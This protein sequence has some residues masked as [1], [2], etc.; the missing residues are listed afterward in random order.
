MHNMKF[1]VIGYLKEKD[2]QKPTKKPLKEREVV[3][4]KTVIYNGITDN[5]EH[6][7]KKALIHNWPPHHNDDYFGVFGMYA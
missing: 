5:L 4:L 1:Q 7:C 2:K 3:F 6:V